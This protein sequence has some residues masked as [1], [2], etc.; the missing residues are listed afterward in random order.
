MEVCVSGQRLK[1][2]RPRKENLMHPVKI[3]ENMPLKCELILFLLHL[4]LLFQ[5]ISYFSSVGA[6]SKLPSKS[7]IFVFFSI[8]KSNISVYKK[9]ATHILLFLG[10]TYWYV[11]TEIYTVTFRCWH[12]KFLT[13]KISK[14]SLF[15]WHFEWP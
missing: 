9:S 8:S 3:F 14:K 5:L 6:S 12:K 13:V 7:W 15:S 2:Y 10:I 11:F 1:W 4:K